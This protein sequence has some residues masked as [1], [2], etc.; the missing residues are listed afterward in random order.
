L[1]IN[2]AVAASSLFS[3]SDADSDAIVQ[4]EFWDDVAGG[5]T[6]ALN[7][8]AL[9]NNPIPVSAA[10]LAD[11]EYAAGATPGTEQ[12]WVRASD[13]IGWGAWKAWNMTRLHIPNAA[14]VVPQRRKLV[15]DQAVTPGAVR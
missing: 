14:P 11:L 15:L 12:V 13:G 8:V 4:Y 2:N 10:Q 7:G 3:V 1:L 9:G 6:F 5:G